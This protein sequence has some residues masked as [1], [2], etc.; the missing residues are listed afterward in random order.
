MNERVRLFE[1]SGYKKESLAFFEEK[2]STLGKI[3][4]IK[5]YFNEMDAIV[6]GYY[7]VS[8]SEKYGYLGHVAKF[9]GYS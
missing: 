1:K 9:I 6:D 7:E 5:A 3:Q 4:K 8:Y 2:R